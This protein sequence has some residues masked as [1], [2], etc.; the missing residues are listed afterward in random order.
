VT[1]VAEQPQEDYIGPDEPAGKLVPFPSRDSAYEIELD[2]DGEDPAPV[3]AVPV[4]L[5]PLGGQRRP[6]IPP[7][8]RT[9]EGI[10]KHAAA[11][12]ANIG[13]PLAF[14]AVRAPWYLAQSAAWAVVGIARIAE[15]QRR[16]WWM[17]EHGILVSLAIHANNPKEYRAL[18]SHVRKV[19]GERGIVIGL[20]ALAIL[21]LTVTMLTW[22]PW[23]GWAMLAAVAV[24]LLARAGRPAHMPIITPSMTT[25]RR[26]V[27]SADKILT[28][29]YAAKLGDPDKPG[30]RVTFGSQAERDGDGTRVVVDLPPGRTFADAMKARPAFA[31]GL[32]VKLSQVYFTEDPSSER[33]VVAWIADTDPLAIPAGRTPLLDCK[34]RNIWRPAPFGLDERGRKVTL[35]LLWISVLIGAQPR[36]GKT[37]SAR[38]LAL[39]AALDPHV[40]LTVIDGKSSPDWRS[41]RFVAHRI[42]FGTH[43]TRDGDPIEQVLDALREI[44]A[45]IMGANDFLSTLSTTEC[46]YGKNTEELSR[47]YPQLRIWVLVMEEFQVY[48]ETEDQEVNKEIAGLLSYILAVGPSVGVTLL[49]CSQKPSGIGAGDVA[50]LFTRFR[51]NHTVRFALKC[52]ARTVSEAILGTEAY[53]EGYDATALPSGARYRGVGLLYGADDETPT[54]RTYLADGRDAEVI[55]LAAR[56][57]REQA[58]TLTGMAANEDL[59]KPGRDVLADV[60]A[61]F[62]GREAGLQWQVLAER[63]AARIPERWEGATADAVSAQLRDLR[64][65]SVDVK[66]DGRALK[67]CRKAAVEQA[68]GQR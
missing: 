1:I 40:R 59:V 27:I 52:G 19:R 67:G 60:H 33:R 25:P 17:P 21:A 66:A 68:M 37:F 47:K 16:W 22:S 28:A 6:V 57:Y 49:D 45:H 15:R 8:L 11:Q 32:D 51:D 13:H 64:V 41:F 20:E 10:R 62:T 7:H 26:R 18:V 35:L 5:P 30:Q 29:C 63:L 31:S 55:L 56:Q 44:K 48:F 65:P 24:P 2:D 46:P 3:L 23:W 14:H 4:A 54:V 36:K 58:G 12:A 9:R 39:Y 50:R 42:I 61:M 53:Q 43:P 38:L 34:P